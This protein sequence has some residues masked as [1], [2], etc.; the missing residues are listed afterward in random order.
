[1]KSILCY[2][3]SNTYGLKS[4]LI[5]RYPREVDN[6][7]RNYLHLRACPRSRCAGADA[8]HQND[9]RKL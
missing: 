9:A 3:D 6:H 4:D 7:R 5:T 2:G 1:M 8:P